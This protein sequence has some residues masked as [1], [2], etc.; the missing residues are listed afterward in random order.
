MA[1]RSTNAT[2]TIE[3]LPGPNDIPETVEDSYNGTE[4]QTLV[5]NAANGVLKNDSTP[6]STRWSRYSTP[7]R[8]TARSRLNADGSFSYV[9]LANF[10]GTDSFL[11][12]AD[13]TID[14]SAPTLVTLNI[15]NVADRPIVA[16]DIF[17]AQPGQVAQRPGARRARQ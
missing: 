2:A 12:V 3:V 4:D 1:A 16:D 14:L 11:Y 8:A 15:A 7:R 13:D 17:V 10:A 5:V 9:P 6:T